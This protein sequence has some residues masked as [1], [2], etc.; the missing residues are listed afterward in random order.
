MYDDDICLMTPSPA[1]LQQLTDI[2]YNYSVK[3]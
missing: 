2:C 3:K 1:S